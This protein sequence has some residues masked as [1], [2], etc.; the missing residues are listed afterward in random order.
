MTYPARR[1][2]QQRYIRRA[3]EDIVVVGGGTTMRFGIQFATTIGLAHPFLQ[4]RPVINRH[5]SRHIRLYCCGRQ[6]YLSSELS[7]PSHFSTARWPG[8]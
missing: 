1:T 6:D 8:C 7:D 3:P 2:Y 4:P 5:G